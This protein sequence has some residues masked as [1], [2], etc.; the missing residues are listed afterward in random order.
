M[1]QKNEVSQ[2]SIKV[3]LTQGYITSKEAEQM[4]KVYLQKI[5]SSPSSIPQ[6]KPKVSI[7]VQ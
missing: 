7:T 4:L 6:S 5:N 2:S 3:A 1:T